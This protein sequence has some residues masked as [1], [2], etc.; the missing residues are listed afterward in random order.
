M[1]MSITNLKHVFLF[2]QRKK[3]WELQDGI[4]KNLI[5]KAQGEI[6]L[7]KAQ[8]KAIRAN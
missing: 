2:S 8:K 6:N 7:Q 3:T 5:K 1:L 4:R